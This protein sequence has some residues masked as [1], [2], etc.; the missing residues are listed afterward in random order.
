M[1]SSWAKMVRGDAKRH[2]VF[3][4]EC[5]HAS[6]ALARGE[7]LAALSTASLV[8]SAAALGLLQSIRVPVLSCSTCPM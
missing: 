7:N 2:A 1:A 5:Q 4:V 6:R 3:Y 8:V